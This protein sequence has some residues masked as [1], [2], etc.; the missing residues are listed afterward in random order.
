MYY[1]ILKIK[2]KIKTD[3]PIAF[4]VAN[5]KGHFRHKSMHNGICVQLRW[6]AEKE[7]LQNTNRQW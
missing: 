3:V 7:T 1:N 4:N 6:I 5:A 2:N